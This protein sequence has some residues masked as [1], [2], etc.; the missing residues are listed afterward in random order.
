MIRVR[1]S[2]AGVH[3]LTEEAQEVFEAVPN[4]LEFRL[5]QAAAEERETHRYKNQTGH[6]QA[7]TQ[8]HVI[9]VAR[10]NAVFTCEMGEYYASYVH[11][12][13][14]SRFEALMERAQK[15][16]ERDLARNG[17]RLEK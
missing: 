16:Y 7:G 4:D 13:G 12:R 1:V 17:R 10:D 9:S 11:D 3:R 15:A 5:E 14:L 6:L 2:D 8:M